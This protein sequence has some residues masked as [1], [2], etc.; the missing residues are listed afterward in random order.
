MG[1]VAPAARL[2]P[3]ADTVTLVNDSVTVGDID[4]AGGDDT[5]ML[6]VAAGNAGQMTGDILAAESLT[7]SGGGLFSLTG[8]AEVGFASANINAGVL[9]VNNGSI[10]GNTDIN[11]G[12]TLRTADY[13]FDGDV[14]NDGV[15]D[16]TAGLLDISGDYS[17]GPDGRLL[18]RSNLAGTTS[19]RIEATGSASLDGSVDVTVTDPENLVLGHNDIV[20]VD[21]AGGRSG[22]FADGDHNVSTAPERVSG[23]LVYN[24]DQAIL[25]ITLAPDAESLLGF[26]ESAAVASAQAGRVL[27]R[28]L[29]VLRNARRAGEHPRLA[30]R[31]RSLA[32]AGPAPAGAL[33]G[34]DY[35]P[36]RTG[37]WGEFYADRADRESGD[38]LP[39]FRADT[40]GGML[41]YDHGIGDMALGIAGG[42]SQTSVHAGVSSGFVQSAYAAAY[43][44]ADTQ[45]GY[46]E[47]AV[48]WA[49]QDY[50]TRRR[51]L[52]GDT[53]ESNHDGEAYGARVAAG[54]DLTPNVAVFDQLLYDRV[55]ED[56][57]SENGAPGFN[58]AVSPEDTDSLRNRLGLRVGGLAS[59]DGTGAIY[60]WLELAW[61]HDFDVDDP[62]VAARPAGAAGPT[63]TAERDD[64]D[65]DGIEARAGVAAILRTG[66]TF[67][68]QAHGESRGDFE[69]YGASL[70]VGYSFD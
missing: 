49:D 40:A 45:A 41:G 66:L 59:A 19:T 7:K 17:Q 43:A 58:Q 70:Q 69:G 61:T 13:A 64:I 18:L 29:R 22:E 12:G 30:E 36:T 67:S 34:R 25:R 11:P 23:G 57:Y 54:V 6:D 2:G 42:Y 9:A 26:G 35:D 62:R 1:A 38:D 39:G 8:D 32:L 63:V 53:A 16:S 33:A 21:A 68:L 3:G 52:G 48:H 37:P 47:G 10:T 51:T 50:S 56:G 5:V 24:P 14:A 44:G 65:E 60:P 55:E 28:R 31:A 15:L 46:V 4:L 27:D 20:L